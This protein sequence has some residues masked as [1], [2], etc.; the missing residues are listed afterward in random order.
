MIHGIIVAAILGLAPLAA[1]APLVQQ[2]PTAVVADPPADKEFPAGLAVVSFPSATTKD[3]ENRRVPFNP[4]GRVAAIL[5]PRAV[6]GPDA[7]VFGSAIGGYQPNIQTAWE[8]LRLFA[9]G[10]DP[11][12]GREGAQWNRQQLQRIDLRWHDLR[13]EGACRLLAD[14]VDIRII[15]ADARPREHSTD[16]TLPERHRRR[17][18]ERIGGELEQQ[19]PTASPGVGS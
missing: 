13:H 2:V 7:F 16:A 17:T 1:D 5:E 10:I 14:G 18:Q 8:S 9:N 12:P 4:K 11:K 6:L 15:L 3:K 19:R